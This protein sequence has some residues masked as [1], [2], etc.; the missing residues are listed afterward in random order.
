MDSLNGYQMNHLVINV[1]LWCYSHILNLVLSDITKTSIATA[2]VFSLLN[3]LTAFFKESYQRMA[4][5][6]KATRSDVKHRK[7]QLIGE[8]RWWAKEGALSKIFGSIK[9]LIVCILNY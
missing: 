3:R 1:H 8:T 7:L 5:W 9:P 4:V 2:S 6:S